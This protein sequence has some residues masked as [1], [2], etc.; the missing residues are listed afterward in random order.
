MN[1]SR[2]ALVVVA[3]HRADSLTAHIAGLVMKR[4]EEAGYR[5]DPLNLHAE[6]YDPRMT[7]ADQPDWS[8]R[9][10]VYSEETE[11]HMRRV[12]DADV[13]IPVF[14][15]YWYSV[16][17]ILKGWIDRVWNYG[18]AYGR[19]EPRLASKPRRMLWIG[20][21]GAAADDP[22][23][24]E[25]RRSLESFLRD[26]VSYYGGIAEAAVELLLDTEA[27]PQYVGQDGSF[28]KGEPL[29]GAEREAHYQALEEQAVGFVE[30]FL[31]LA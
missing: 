19:S 14:P 12:L 20:L 7:V 25:M 3:H 29:A 31:D 9:D 5:I 10:K 2:T 11:A 18:F 21:A 13:I 28:V 6:D 27:E 26:G 30:K 16:P 23:V 4:L 1:E 22:G 24:A 8:D 15:V 17:A